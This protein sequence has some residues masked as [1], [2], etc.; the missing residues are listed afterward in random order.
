MTQKNIILNLQSIYKYAHNE[1]SLNNLASLILEEYL[2]ELG[3]TRNT[4]KNV[5][6][7]KLIFLV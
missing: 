6:L 5:S 7:W 3:E 1:D 4:C 2:K